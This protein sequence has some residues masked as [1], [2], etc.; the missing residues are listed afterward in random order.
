[1]GIDRMYYSPDFI[2][3]LKARGHD[4]CVE[5]FETILKELSARPGVH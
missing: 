3:C 5:W 4:T 1:M 2:K